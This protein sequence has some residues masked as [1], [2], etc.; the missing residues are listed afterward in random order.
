VSSIFKIIGLTP[1]LT[2]PD[3]EYTLAQTAGLEVCL[4]DGK[5]EVDNNLVE[6]AIRPT[7]SGK[8][9]WICIGEAEARIAVHLV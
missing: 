6:N 9:N 8:K 5:V 2:L 1:C 7:A 4:E 3:T